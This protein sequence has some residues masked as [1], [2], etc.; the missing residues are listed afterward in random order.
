MNRA[1]SL[2]GNTFVR[3]VATSLGVATLLA[4]LG[5]FPTVRLAGRTAVSAMLAGIGISLSA[6]I[7]GAIPMSRSIVVREPNKALIGVLAST[8][9]RF[10]VVLAL[11]ASVALAGWFDR[12]P[13][14]LW[15]GISYLVMLVVD[16]LYA[17]SRVQAGR[18]EQT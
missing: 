4:L 9:V 12:R 5:Y 17:L 3:L 16:T 1:L 8:T 2:T 18:R 11:T 6:G 7:I 13:L 14:L 15:V 10:L